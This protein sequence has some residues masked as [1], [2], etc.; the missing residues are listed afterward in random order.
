M[1]SSP[2]PMECVSRVFVAVLTG[3]RVQNC[4]VNIVSW[5]FLA[6]ASHGLDGSVVCERAI[7]APVLTN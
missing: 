2:V 3:R 5:S 6:S 1:S 4:V 7:K